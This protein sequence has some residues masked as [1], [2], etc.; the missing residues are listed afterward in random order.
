LA[1]QRSARR[2]VPLPSGSRTIL[3]PLC[4]GGPI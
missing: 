1:A 4:R 3:P 2:A